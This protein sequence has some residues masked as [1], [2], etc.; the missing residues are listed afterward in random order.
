M[1]I[2]SCFVETYGAIE[3]Q[4]FDFDE[5]LTVFLRDNGTGKTTLASFIRA[6]FY[7]LPPTKT[8]SVTFNDRE[9]FYPFSGGKFGGTLTFEAQGKTYKIERFFDKKSVNKDQ[10]KLYENGD[11]IECDYSVGLRFFGVD[12]RAFTRTVFF[13]GSS[14]DAGDDAAAKLSDKP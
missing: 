2:I 13:D 10:L 12:E 5:N 3:K 4:K 1:K 8:N 7:G 14:A 11:E 9:R 6:M